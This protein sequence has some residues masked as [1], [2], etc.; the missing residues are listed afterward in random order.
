MG[1][2]QRQ[3]GRNGAATQSRPFGL[4]SSLRVRRRVSSTL[5]T[6]EDDDGQ[7]YFLVKA[8]SFEPERDSYIDERLVD[9]VPFPL[10]G[11]A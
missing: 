5:W 3:V 7:L 11:T 4:D 9:E 6:F 1:P 10:G 2:R 8:G